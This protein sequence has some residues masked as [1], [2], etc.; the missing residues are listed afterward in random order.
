MIVGKKCVDH[1]DGMFAFAIWD[2]RKKSFLLQ[3]TGLARNLFLYKIMNNSFLPEM[4]ALWAAGIGRKVN[5][6]LLFNYLTIDYVDNPNIPET[7]FEN[8][9]K[10]PAASYLKLSNLQSSTFNFQLL[11][12]SLKM[13]T[14]RSLMPKR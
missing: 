1:F 14:K 2:Q 7:F 5:L 3:E 8:I 4:K 11:G 10:L 6:K 12:Y 13:K 9:S